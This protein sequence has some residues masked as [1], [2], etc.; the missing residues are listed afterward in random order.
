MM[1]LSAIGNANRRRDAQAF[2]AAQWRPFGCIPVV[3]TNWR[4]LGCGQGRWL[5][6]WYRGLGQVVPH[7]PADLAVDLLFDEARPI[8]VAGET[9]P[10]LAVVL[11]HLL[12]GE[13][14]VWEGASTP[15]LGDEVAAGM[16]LRAREAR[17]PDPDPLH[18]RAGPP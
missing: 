7:L 9:V 12:Y 4:V 15:R 10:L 18:L 8:R 13:T 6:W 16:G 2:A 14:V 17:K 1:A 5:S 3:A 11:V